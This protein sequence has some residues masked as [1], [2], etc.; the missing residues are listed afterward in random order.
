MGNFYNDVQVQPELKAVYQSKSAMSKNILHDK[1]RNRKTR[2]E[3]VMLHLCFKKL[4]RMNLE[5][6]VLIHT[7]PLLNI[8]LVVFWGQTR[9]N[10]IC[11]LIWIWVGISSIYALN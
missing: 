5:M 2:R 11:I 6:L 9:I 10:E 8:C 3:L 1:P 7:M 4:K